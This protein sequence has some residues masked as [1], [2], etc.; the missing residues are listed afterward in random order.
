MCQVF[1]REELEQM[2]V[3]REWHLK[4]KWGEKDPQSFGSLHFPSAIQAWNNGQLSCVNKY[5]VSWV[6]THC[7]IGPDINS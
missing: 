2:G 7:N 6:L 5:R 4:R 3:I 1:R